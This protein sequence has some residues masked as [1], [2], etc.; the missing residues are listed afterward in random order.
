MEFRIRTPTE[1]TV[2]ITDQVAKVL[3]GLALRSGVCF[4]FVQHTSC[5]VTLTED[6]GNLPNDLLG[7]LSTIAPKHAG[8][9]HDRVDAN[10]HAHIRAAIIGSSVYVPLT[11]GQLD[12]GTW[13]QLLLVEF[14]GPRE[15]TVRVRVLS[16]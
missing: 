3:E 1:G 5:A 13:Q 4:V 7:V 9:V 6:D 11:D 16:D 10:A 2:N 15:R 14:D 12:L 8:Y